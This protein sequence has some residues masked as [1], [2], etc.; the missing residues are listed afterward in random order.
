MILEKVSFAT[1][2]LLILTL[3]FDVGMKIG[4]KTPVNFIYVIAL[5]GWAIIAWR[6]YL[7]IHKA[8]RSN[9]SIS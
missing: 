6:D 1:S 2:I 8:N 3:I 7:I 9:D 5:V 4:A